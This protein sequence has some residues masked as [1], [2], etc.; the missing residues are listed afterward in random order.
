M[1][2]LYS[3]KQEIPSVMAGF[4][5]VI[6]STFWKTPAHMP[7]KS[8][9]TTHIQIPGMSH[10]VKVSDN[11]YTVDANGRLATI[12]EIATSIAPNTTVNYSFIWEER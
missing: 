1:A 5:V 2:R 10:I 3:V 4:F 12:Q 9:F 7:S 6:L 8:T 11:T